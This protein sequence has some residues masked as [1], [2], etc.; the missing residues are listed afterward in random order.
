[1][2][3]GRESN[4]E[5]RSNREE[6]IAGGNSSAVEGGVKKGLFLGG[7]AAGFSGS[8][9]KAIGEVER[10]GDLGMN[11]ESLAMIFVNSSF[12]GEFV[13]GQG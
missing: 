13:V 2:A 4:A 6:V 12:S 5:K 8:L 7:V 9:L 10:R 11:A 3:H 1:L